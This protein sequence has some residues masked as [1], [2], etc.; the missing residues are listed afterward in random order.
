[1]FLGISTYTFPWLTEIKKQNCKPVEVALQLLS[2]AAAHNII[3]MQ[4]G[5]NLPL[6]NMQQHELEA[7]KSF[8]S[9]HNIKIQ[10]GAKKLSLKNAE[11]YL[12]IAAYFQ[13]PFLRMIIDDED[14]HPSA[15]EV[16]QIINGLLPLLKEKN[17]KLAIENH[18]RF[19]AVTL[20]NIMEKTSPEFTGVCLDTANS[21]G[22]GEGITE[23]L[24]ILKPYVINLHIKD[25]LI[26]RVSH[27]MGFTV[28]GVAAGEGIIDIPSIIFQLNE[29]GRCE[30]ATLELWLN[31]CDD[32]EQTIFTE[33]QLAEKSIHY[34]KQF[35]S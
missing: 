9:A 1:M 10:A 14:Y 32:A 21:L 5:D 24:Q 30:T 31:N 7:I 12:S 22:A 17:I 2:V 15:E 27:R 11:Q 13:S 26:K 25:V 18:D 3:F 28:E 16:I 4:F 6:H 34:L 20:K 29:T 23:V 33:K 19:R 35:L 8:A